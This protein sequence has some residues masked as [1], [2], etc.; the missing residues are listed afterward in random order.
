MSKL[1]S[2]G[3]VGK[4]NGDSRE[5]VRRYI[6]LT[7]LI[8]ELLHLV[9]NSVIYKKGTHLTLGLTTAVELSYLSRD[10]QK[11]LFYTIEYE[12]LTPSRAQALKIRNLADKNKLN[13]DLLEKILG[14]EKGNQ[15]EQISFNKERIMSVLPQDILKRDK[16]YIEEYIVNV[17]LKYKNHH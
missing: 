16:K 11:L 9:D 17:L 12:D 14:E 6:R 15:H 2:A 13:F 10:A 7:Y 3:K 1:T 5:Q 4:N 8:P